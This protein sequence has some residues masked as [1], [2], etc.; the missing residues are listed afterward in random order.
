MYNSQLLSF[1]ARKY[2]A[3]FK[4]GEKSIEYDFSQHGGPKISVLKQDDE[5]WND[6]QQRLL[7]YV[8]ENYDIG[9]F[10]D[11]VLMGV[12][13]T[14]VYNFPQNKLRIT[15][16]TNIFPMVIPKLP[17]SW[18]PMATP[19][20][21]INP[22]LAQI[23]REFDHKRL[24]RAGVVDYDDAIACPYNHLVSG[25]M[26]HDVGI[27]SLFILCLRRVSSYNLAYGGNKFYPYVT[28]ACFHPLLGLP[29]KLDRLAKRHASFLP[30]FNFNDIHRALN[31]YYSY[32]VTVVKVPFKFK[33][34]DINLIKFN[35]TKTGFRQWPDLDPVVLDDITTVKFTSKP[36]KK[37]ARCQLTR[38]FMSSILMAYREVFNCPVPINKHLKQH[39]TALAIKEQ[40]ISVTDTAEYSDKA[41]KDIFEKARL[42]FQSNDWM[43][44][45]LF[46]TRTK[47][48]RTYFPDPFDIYGKFTLGDLCPMH[49]TVTISIGMTWTQGGAYMLYQSINGN[50]M[51]RY[52]RISLEGDSADCVN[53]T[54]RKVSD[55]DF[56][57]ASGDIKS[58]DTS[59]SAILLVLYL[60]FAQIWVKR[61]DDDVDYRVFQYILEA[62]S[63]HLAGKVVRWIEDFVLLLGVM[64]SGSLET[65]HGDSWVVGIIYWLG[66]V[67]NVMDK[68]PKDVRA[69]I[70]KM[71]AYRQIGIW[72]YGDDFLQLYRKTYGKYKISD[73]L[74]VDGFADYI[75]RSHNVE[76]KNK[77]SFTTFL[78]YYTVRNNEV[79]GVV[80]NGERNGVVDYAL[81][82][83]YLKRAFIS[84]SNFNLEMHDS[85]IAPV[86]PYRPLNQYQWRMG[87]PRDR[88]APVYMNLARLIG[89]AYDT[90]GVDP[91]AYSMLRFM[92]YRLFEVG[93]KMTSK[94]YLTKNLPEWLK[95]DDKY[96]RK[97]NFKVS[98][99]GFPTREYLLSLN[100][101]N[102]EYHKP[103]FGVRTWQECQDDMEWW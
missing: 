88:A 102:R 99:A 96:L 4:V 9:R 57:I 86:V 65:S 72:V 23:V 66:Y 100:R 45:Q 14:M 92:F 30:G 17:N 103:K 18:L 51:D 81:G 29:S 16:A 61:D 38:E 69:V 76:M 62:C 37:Q 49:R 101:F 7:L 67:F 80:C 95:A 41:I 85:E 70:W 48:E 32:C 68:S 84:S 31:F 44:H 34:Q 87:V 22:I 2:S 46:S 8:N 94:E 82:P 21:M 77:Q 63:E 74:S 11:R 64:P 97:I 73:F 71:M 27:P 83:T 39:I 43:L 1:V 3:S 42:F 12:K 24:A 28:N 75:L 36:T 40:N 5:S 26:R 93:V 50:R 25:V 33:V 55:G 15:D 35:G 10:R 90:L 52:E 19:M 89:L 47:A 98:T 91:V 79:M 53:C 58:L 60:M 59:I 56:I 54:W 6:A 13:G 20:K 78:T